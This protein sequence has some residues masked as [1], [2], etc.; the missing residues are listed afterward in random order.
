MSIFI[1]VLILHKARIGVETS[2]KCSCTSGIIADANHL[3][4]EC[5]N[6]TKGRE[7]L[8]RAV[9][10]TGC[11]LSANLNTILAADDDSIYTELFEFIIIN[12]KITL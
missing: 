3:I 7:R 11:P 6:I 4:L 2:H 9:I 12:D 8:W 10:A 1:F 5:A